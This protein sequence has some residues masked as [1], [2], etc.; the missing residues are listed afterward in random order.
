M[1]DTAAHRRPLGTFGVNDGP[2]SHSVL[3][4]SPMPGRSVADAEVL[5][6]AVRGF[7]HQGEG[8]LEY[9]RLHAIA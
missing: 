2:W 9:G 1:G 5:R 6:T 7:R 8:S 4:V 3:S